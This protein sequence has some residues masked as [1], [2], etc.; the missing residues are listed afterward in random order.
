VSAPLRILF[1]AGAGL[2]TTAA[3]TAGNVLAIQGMPEDEW[4]IRVALLQRCVS[5][6]QVIGLIAAGLLAHRD[7][8]DGF[9]LAGAALLAAGLLA[10]V[11][12]PRRR[13]RDAKPGPITAGDTTAPG[14][15]RRWP[16]FSRQQIDGY[17]SV[18]NSPMRRFL[19]IWL[20]AY[21]AMNG[22]A[23]L[24]PVVMTRQFGMDPILPSGAYAVGVGVSLMLYSFAGATTHRLGGERMLAAGFAARLAILGLLSVLGWQPAGATGWP[25]LVGF[26]LIQFVWPLIAVAANSLSV[27]YMPAARG[28]SVGLFNA[29]TSLSSAVGSA[30]AGVIYDFGGFAALATGAF[31]AVA[32]ALL[33]SEFWLRQPLASRQQA[34]L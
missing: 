12:A 13:G 21:S 28:E 24:F 3:T 7:P 6:G 16:H 19:L 34:H 1:A 10:F 22:F 26:A 30:L 5:A 31:A 11:S 15:H 20:I 27:R 2:G 4:D 8:G 23:A 14:P 29:T 32:A 17:L 9:R 25:V 33:L 18:I